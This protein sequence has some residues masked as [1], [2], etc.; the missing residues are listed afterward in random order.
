MDIAIL[1]TLL[2]I[3]YKSSKSLRDSSEIF[4]EFNV[5]RVL[6]VLVFIYPLGPLLLIFG[7]TQPRILLYLLVA[8]CYLPQLVIA[9]NQINTL[10]LFGTDR[11]KEATD[12]L[13]LAWLGAIVGLIYLA[14]VLIIVF[15]V[16]SFATS[17]H[18]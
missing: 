7:S 13:S 16:F 3:T 4:K 17:N 15:S 1:I 12:A 18:Y 5:S 14:V 11:V 2:F 10:S 8:A 9:R 6:S